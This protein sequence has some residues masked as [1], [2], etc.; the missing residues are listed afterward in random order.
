MPWGPSSISAVAEL[1]LLPVATDS[2]RICT[3]EWGFLHRE[4]LSTT[5]PSYL[6]NVANEQNHLQWIALPLCIDCGQICRTDKMNQAD[7]CHWYTTN[8]YEL[9]WQESEPRILV[10]KIRLVQV[11]G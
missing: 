3:Y 11:Q 5:D 4:N 8:L 10:A 1:V 9:G 2:D 7:W 6:S